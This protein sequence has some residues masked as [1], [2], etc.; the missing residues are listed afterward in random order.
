MEKRDSSYV[1][2]T[3]RLKVRSIEAVS[4]E[5]RDLK[6][7]HKGLPAGSVKNLIREQLEEMYYKLAQLKKEKLINK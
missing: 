2:P 3:K 6:K 4:S 1:Y 7:V 5:I